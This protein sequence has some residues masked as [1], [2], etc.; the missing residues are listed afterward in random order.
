MHVAGSSVAKAIHCTTHYCLHSYYH[1]QPMLLRHYVFNME[2]IWR[3][4]DRR[5]DAQ[6][7]L[8]EDVKGVTFADVT[9]E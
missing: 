1:I 7:I 8:I 3:V 6:S 5:G 2:Y 9:G 4:V